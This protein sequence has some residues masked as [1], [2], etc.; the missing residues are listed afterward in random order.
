[1]N[2]ADFFARLESHAEDAERIA[3]I[4]KGTTLTYA[5]L[6]AAVAERAKFLRS[7]GIKMLATFSDN[8]PAWIVTDLAAL[9]ANVPHVP[10]PLF[11][12]PAQIAATL[13]ATAADAVIAPMG[14][15]RSFQALGFTIVDEFDYVLVLLRRISVT[16]SLP[17][18]TTKITFTS[19]S[20]GNPK[21][22]CLSAHAMF[23]VADAIAQSTTELGITRHLNALPLPVLLE[24]IAGV[25]APL[26]QGATCVVLPLVDVGLSGS[27][28][29]DPA[30]FHAALVRYR[31]QSVITLPQMLQAYVASL[32]RNE[33]RSPADLALVAVGGARVG[34]ALLAQAQELGLP[35]MEG[36][37]LS[38]GASV[39][40]LNLPGKS[41]FGSAGRALGHARLRV[42]SDGEI[43]IAG[44]L[45]LGYLG[46]PVV[47]EQWLPTGD[48]GHLDQDGFLFVSGRKKNVLITAYGRNVSPEWVEAA[49]RDHPLI[50][51][52]VV[53]GDAEP[54]L[55][56]VLWL[57]DSTLSDDAVQE[58]IHEV[59]SG[60]PDYARIGP[61]CRAVADYS[62]ATGLATA[63]GR[64]RR[65]H[66]FDLHNTLFRAA[67][68]NSFARQH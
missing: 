60:L 19:G 31:V 67:H 27:S 42:A 18:G 44:S 63:N 21:G 28:S 43:E 53:L 16:P 56:A 12:T 68:L 20:T 10:L 64:P 14:M 36:Y 8:D 22:V 65:Q 47:T 1:M 26:L 30:L 62:V 25:Y 66:I 34:D 40:T 58:A 59:N 48:L 13:A 45:F 9:A 17:A 49:L 29:F 33:E 6:T 35:V 55:G 46:G 38:E 2:T 23:D 32:Q 52:A 3:L 50:A 54:V 4:G 57:K 5:D 61:W 51:Q 15:A 39:Q 41:R 24:N 11:F 37:G 7:V